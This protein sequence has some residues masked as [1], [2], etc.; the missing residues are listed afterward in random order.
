MAA[1]LR[2]LD[3]VPDD[4]SLAAIDLLGIARGL[5]DTAA[6]EGDTDAGLVQARLERAAFG[7]LSLAP[8]REA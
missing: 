5:L 8:P 7:Y 6:L 4:P 3:A 2:A 1:T